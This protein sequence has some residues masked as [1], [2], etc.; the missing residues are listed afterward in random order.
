MAFEEHIKKRPNV[1][2]VFGDQH[3]AGSI[4]GDGF[5]EAIAP[6]LESLPAREFFNER[7]YLCPLFL[8]DS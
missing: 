3:R 4:L 7:V 6:A 1:L 5:S 8:N 2:Y